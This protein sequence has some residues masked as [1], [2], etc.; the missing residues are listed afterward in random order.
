MNIKYATLIFALLLFTLAVIPN[1]LFLTEKDD[2]IL[3][4]FDSPGGDVE[5]ELEIH[6]LLVHGEDP[7]VNGSK[8]NIILCK[9]KPGKQQVLVRIRPNVLKKKK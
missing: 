3:V 8:G 2:A 5:V 1:I 9:T 4:E 6:P 7:Y